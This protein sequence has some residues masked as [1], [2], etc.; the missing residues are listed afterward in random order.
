MVLHPLGIA[1]TDHDFP[2]GLLVHS[3]STLIKEKEYFT[4]KWMIMGMDY[5]FLLKAFHSFVCIWIIQR[6][7]YH[8]R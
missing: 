1:L 4:V 7:L 2:G 5:I 8:D 6:F 3:I